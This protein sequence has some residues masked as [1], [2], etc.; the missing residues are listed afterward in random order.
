MHGILTSLTLSTRMLSGLT[1]PLHS[2]PIVFGKQAQ[3]AN[4][5][6]IILKVSANGAIMDFCEELLWRGKRG[7]QLVAT[8]SSWSLVGFSVRSLDNPRFIYAA[9][10][11][12]SLMKS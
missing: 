4:T 12:T 8:D 11:W 3:S 7:S 9:W 2:S 1:T 6:L 10:V 5:E